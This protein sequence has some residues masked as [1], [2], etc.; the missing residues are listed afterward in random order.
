VA[1]NPVLSEHGDRAY[2]RAVMLPNQLL[3]QIGDNTRHPMYHLLDTLSTL[4]QAYEEEQTRIPDGVDQSQA[5]PTVQPPII[6]IHVSDLA[7]SSARPMTHLSCAT[8]GLS[9]RLLPASVSIS[10]GPYYLHDLGQTVGDFGPLPHMASRGSGCGRGQ[11][12][13]RNGLPLA[14]IKMQV[15]LAEI[16]TAGQLDDLV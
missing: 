6:T 14:P 5:M 7:L 11:R 10:V 3:G 2:P 16:F 4:I 15:S 12:K 1:F 8:R 9:I 13:E